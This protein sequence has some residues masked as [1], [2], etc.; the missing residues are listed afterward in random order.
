MTFNK[1]NSSKIGLGD[2]VDVES[3]KKTFARNHPALFEHIPKTAGLAIRESLRKHKLWRTALF[4][5]LLDNADRISSYTWVKGE[6]IDEA[7]KDVISFKDGEVIVS[8][9]HHLRLHKDN[10]PHGFYD[11]C[12]K[13]CF[14]RNPYDRFVSAFYYL[15]NQPSNHPFHHADKPHQ[16]LLKDAYKGDIHKFIAECPNYCE[17]GLIFMPQVEFIIDEDGE[18]L[19]MDF[20]G[21]YESFEHPNSVS[22]TACT[23]WELLC[24]E[25]LNMPSTLLQVN[26]THKKPEWEE[27]LD[28]EDIAK[29]NQFYWQDFKFLDYDAQ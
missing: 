20:I 14:V 27:I 16:D 26:K 15:L 13:F 18:T 24:K 7:K 12:F 21:K 1:L 28:A 8:S 6:L 5:H 11:K 10:L 19:L 2:N 4:H 29:L 17:A 9:H 25:Y 3:F 23:D 22:S